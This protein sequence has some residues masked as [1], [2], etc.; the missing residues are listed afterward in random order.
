MQKRTITIKFKSAYHYPSKFI[1]YTIDGGRHVYV[2]LG[3]LRGVYG[4]HLTS[5]EEGN[6]LFTALKLE[7]KDSIDR[8]TVLVEAVDFEKELKSYK[9]AIDPFTCYIDSYK[10]EQEAKAKNCRLEAIVDAEKGE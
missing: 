8:I 1:D 2:F 6:R 9:D 3:C 7:N 4:Y 5:K 10:Q